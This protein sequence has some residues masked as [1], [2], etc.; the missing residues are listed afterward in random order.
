MTGEITAS[1]IINNFNYDRFVA[2]AISSA[3]GQLYP[4]FE[5]V[6][7]DDG[8]SDR[9]REVIA[10]FDGIV[11]VFKPNGGQASAFTAG[12]EASRGEIILFLDADDMLESDALRQV[13]ERFADPQVSKVHWPLREI[14]TDG[15]RT[16]RILPNRKLRRGDL[17]PEVLRYGVPRGWGHGLGH[18]YRRDF[19]QTVMPV[20][21]CGDRHGADSY[22]CVLAPVFG[23]IESIGKPLGCYRT[24]RDNFALGQ[25]VR[26]RLE[27][28]ARRYPYFFDWVAAYL[29]R[30]RG[31]EVDRSQWEGPGSPFAWTVSALE[32]DAE[33]ERLGI[34]QQ[35]F[36]LI[37]DGLFGTE[38]YPMART[39]M[40]RDGEYWGPPANDQEAIEQLE[41]HRAA[42][43]RQIVFAAHCFWWLEHYSGL[44]A[45][46]TEQYRCSRR[47]EHSIVFELGDSAN[48]QQQHATVAYRC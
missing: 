6:V 5:V 26:Y 36:V 9:S 39:M 44:G 10:E 8:S 46:L 41:C 27:R 45:H 33:I 35:P 22:L 21:E 40:E 19:L 16:G 2:D 23:M 25:S 32:L 18:A 3:V 7:V 28:D 24:H 17:L 31:I 47:T 15:E 1:V 14:T 42:G 48:S 4:C 29:K 43:C 30:H 13:A 20:Q 11:P 38:A 37:D 12:F 34:Q